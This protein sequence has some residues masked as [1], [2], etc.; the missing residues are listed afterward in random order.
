MT[1]SIIIV[2]FNSGTLLKDCLD[3]VITSLPDD[4]IIVVDNHPENFD[5]IRFE[6]IY[7]DVI[8]VNNPINNGFGGGNNLGVHSSSGDLLFFL[9]PDTIINNFD[10]EAL[11]SNYTKTTIILQDFHS[12][13]LITCIVSPLNLFL[14]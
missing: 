13:I 7:T 1:I 10:R 5:L 2:A 3:S 8:F 4:E 6:N 12:I 14:R 9:N 11:V